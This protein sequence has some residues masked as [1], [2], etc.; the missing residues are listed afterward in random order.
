MAEDPATPLLERLNFLAIVSAN[1]DEFYMV[2]VGALKEKQGVEHEGLLEA[3]GIRTRALL[4]R[5]ER[6]LAGCLEAL[7]G[8]GIHLRDWPA[9]APT[10]RALLEAQF[11]LEIFPLLTPRAIT[12]SPGFPVP[13]MPHLTPL[14]AVVLQDSRTGPLH[15]AYLRL[16]ER[17]P[18][19]LPIPDSSDFILLEDVVR[20]NLHLVY[21]ERQIEGAWVFRL[22]RA[23]ELDLAD[24]DA[25]NLLQAIEESVGR[26]ALNA[27]VRVEVERVMPQPLRE[28]LLWELRFE[29][30]ADAGAVRE[31]DLVEIGGMV[32]LRSLREL[33][34]AP[35]TNGRFPAFEG[36]APW[37]GERDLWAM[38]RQRDALVYHPYE[39]FADTTARFFSDAADDPAV[40]AI[41]LTL[42][43]V[44]ERSPIVDALTRALERK[45]EVALF[46]ELK[47][48]FDETRNVGWVRR[49]EEAGAT[50]VYGVVGL[51]NHAKVGLVL[52]REDDGLRRYVHIGTGNYN[53]ATAKVYT[54]LS[55]F[56]SDPDLGAD[57][58]DLFNQL[59]GSSRGPAGSFRR[60]AVAPDGLLPWLLERVDREVE[61]ARAGRPARI[62]A[63][64]NGLADTEVVQ[65][66]Y[67]A[68][69]AGVT[70]DLVVRG[71]C[72]LRPGVPGHSDGI[73]VVSRLGRFLEHARIY[74]FGNGGA[75]EY[76][77]GSADWRPRNLRRR[78]EVVA[79]VTDPTAR[80]TLDE[81]LTRELTDPDRWVLEAD[82]SYTRA[83]ASRET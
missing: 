83:G 78:V 39:R 71:V 22:T 9:L 38:L 47:A 13:V 32:D 17:I 21:P 15:F 55:L 64:L 36:R 46:V 3:I 29:R 74:H 80:A 7:A 77:I 37:A 81:M 31:Q 75:E 63:K 14:L 70:I 43:R 11:Q 73:R 26:R 20:A 82:G 27:I 4:A 51:K 48:R 62:R 76:C 79:P 58:H 2:N 61:H 68:S 42:Y 44:G 41:R 28:R 54:D 23:A 1:L 65:A 19:F 30:G 25:G 35:V 67:R 16:P 59:T 34:G 49:L 57:V 45:K 66:L 72:I 33:M 6:T 10:S 18:R 56:S 53:A 69:R 60:V 8:A 24:E 52:R 50:V 40:V 5:Q 12:V